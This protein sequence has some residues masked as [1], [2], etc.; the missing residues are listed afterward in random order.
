[1]FNYSSTPWLTQYW[2]RRICERAYGDDVYGLCGNEDVG[3]MSAWY[4]LAAMG[5]HPFCP[6]SDRYEITSPVFDRVEIELDPDYYTG[7][8]FTVTARNNSPENIYIRSIKLNGKPRDRLYITHGEITAGGHLE[9]EM[10]P[11]PVKL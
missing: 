4:I 2:T 9:L 6:G 7:K 10:G 5:I 11:N 8:K 3:Q 1:M